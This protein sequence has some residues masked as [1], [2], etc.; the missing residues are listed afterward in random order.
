[1]LLLLASQSQNT[2]K[3]LWM[4]STLKKPSCFLILAV[5]IIYLRTTRPINLVSSVLGGGV[6]RIDPSQSIL[7]FDQR[8][9]EVNND[10]I[11]IASHKQAT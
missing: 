10:G 5:T 6:N 11:L 4:N 7:F 8:Y 1:M 2:V 3:F 9:I